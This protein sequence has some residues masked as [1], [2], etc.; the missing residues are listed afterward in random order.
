MVPVSDKSQGS[1]I[2]PVQRRMYIKS[3]NVVKHM[4]TES[5]AFIETTFSVVWA[6]TISS[7]P[8]GANMQLLVLLANSKKNI[9]LLI[10]VV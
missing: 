6:E 8:L 2:S 7:D 10:T 4:E 9:E 1:V 5:Y 3:T